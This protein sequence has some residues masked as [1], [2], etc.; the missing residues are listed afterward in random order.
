ML[1][2]AITKYENKALTIVRVIEV[3]IKIAQEVKKARTRG[4]KLDLSDVTSSPSMMHWRDPLS[5]LIPLSSFLQAP[6]EPTFVDEPC[7]LLG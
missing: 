3:L 5:P 6:R 7:F 4:E 2:E 1:Q